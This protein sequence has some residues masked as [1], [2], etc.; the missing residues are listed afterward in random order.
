LSASPILGS[1]DSTAMSS[2]LRRGRPAS[3]LSTSSSRRW[4]AGTSSGPGW[5]SR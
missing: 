1:P 2:S 3:A 4:R 5:R